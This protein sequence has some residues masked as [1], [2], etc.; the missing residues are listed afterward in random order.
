MAAAT[1]AG[2]EES[3]VTLGTSTATF[4]PSDDEFDYRKG[5]D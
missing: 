3:T 4:D 2:I 5:L 1:L